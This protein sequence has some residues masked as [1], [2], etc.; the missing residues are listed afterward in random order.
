MYFKTMK[1]AYSS[2]DTA[3]VCLGNKTRCLLWLRSNKT[4]TVCLGSICNYN[5]N[6]FFLGVTLPPTTTVVCFRWVWSVLVLYS[7]GYFTICIVLVTAA[8]VVTISWVN[9]SSQ[10][11]K[12]C[13]T[14]YL[15][16][17]RFLVGRVLYITCILSPLAWWCQHDVTSIAKCFILI[18]SNSASYIAKSSLVIRRTDITKFLLTTWQSNV[19]K[20]TLAIWRHPIAKQ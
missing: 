17:S 9:P 6:P 7:T 10:L 19:A 8:A 13:F 18:G 4:C 1:P 20:F 11:L 5:G 16:L 12:P 2:R 3:W 15:V 14:V